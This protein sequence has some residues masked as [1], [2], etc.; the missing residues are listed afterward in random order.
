MKWPCAL[1]LV[2]S[3]TLPAVAAEVAC[4]LG[5]EGRLVQSE[6]SWNLGG[7]VDSDGCAYGID[8]KG[9][10]RVLGLDVVSRCTRCRGTFLTRGVGGPLPAFKAGAPA[11]VQDE[12]KALVVA[13]RKER[14]INTRDF[15]SQSEQFELAGRIYN[16]LG[17]RLGLSEGDRRALVGRL[18]LRAAWGARGAAV[19]QG[20]DAGFRP[21]SMR[22]VG[23]HLAILAARHDADP[24]AEPSVR[25]IDR[26]LEDLGVARRALAARMRGASP[27]ERFAHLA[28]RAAL[29][30]LE[31]DLYQRKAQ[32]LAELT[33]QQPLGRRELGLARLRAWIRTGDFRRA[34]EGL[35]AFKGDVIRRSMATW[36]AEER[37]LLGLA[38]AELRAAGE[39]EKDPRRAG[40][41]VFLAGDSARRQ[42][43]SSLARALLDKARQLAPQDEAGRRAALLLGQ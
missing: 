14:S 11:G 39:L 3:L 41:L 25:V 22:E 31:R 29:D 16:A 5:D 2:T 18:Y 34:N 21:R 19:L 28:A 33:R 26:S 37:R 15:L 27:A 35:A 17:A 30:R 32:R 23:E 10:R 12:V 20:P 42:G 1:L 38:E 7:G 40:L 4:P 8:A 36:V 9:G 24:A 6:R 13:F 43:K